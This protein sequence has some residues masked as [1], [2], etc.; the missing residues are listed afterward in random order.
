MLSIA[1]PA[2]PA[3]PFT[4]SSLD[5]N[6]H[7][8]DTSEPDREV[9]SSAHSKVFSLVWFCKKIFDISTVTDLT[10]CSESNQ[11]TE[12]YLSEKSPKYSTSS[13]PFPSKSSQ[14]S[15]GLGPFSFKSVQLPKIIPLKF[16]PFLVQETSNWAASLIAKILPSLSFK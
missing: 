3:L 11:T 15:N 7:V 14:L 8:K 6:L 13:Y 9:H 12:L 4:P 1:K 5:K 16:S 10:I 2:E